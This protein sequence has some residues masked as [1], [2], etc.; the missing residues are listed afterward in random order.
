MQLP[1]F[2]HVN[3]DELHSPEVPAKAWTISMAKLA[4]NRNIVIREH[5]LLDLWH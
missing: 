5:L 2:E 4:T 3:W 1:L